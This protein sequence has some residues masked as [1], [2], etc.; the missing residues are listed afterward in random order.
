M[1]SEQIPAKEI[2]SRVRKTLVSKGTKGFLQ[3]EK[4]L[5]VNDADSDGKVSFDEFKRV[6]YDQKVGIS[7]VEAAQIFSSF[8]QQNSGF[9]AYEQIM[10]SLRSEIS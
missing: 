7:T 6:I 1:S 5:K 2:F 4:Q 10:Q 8:D 3:F 9:V